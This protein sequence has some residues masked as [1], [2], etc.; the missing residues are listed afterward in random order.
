MIFYKKLLL[1]YYIVLYNY[2]I[3]NAYMN[4]TYV[5]KYFAIRRIKIDALSTKLYNFR[6]GNTFLVLVAPL[7]VARMKITVE[8]NFLVGINCLSLSTKRSILL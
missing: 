2:D 5:Q 6:S 1:N 8:V 7:D 4:F 3:F